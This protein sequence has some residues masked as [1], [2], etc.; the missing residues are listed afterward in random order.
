MTLA[1]G[2]L[3]AVHAKNEADISALIWKDCLVI[4]VT[5]K[6]KVQNFVYSVWPMGK[7]DHWFLLV[8]K[9]S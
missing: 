1:D 9:T 6:I 3:L 4:L 5:R 8:E 7:H 2:G